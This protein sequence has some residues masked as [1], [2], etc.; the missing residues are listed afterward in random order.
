M[1]PQVLLILAAALALALPVFASGQDRPASDAA[2]TA[3]LADTKAALRDLWVGHI[4]WVRNVVDARFEDN[5]QAA[6]AAEQQVVANA[7]AIAGSIEPF[8]GAA[9]SEKLFGQLAG[10]WG[11]ISEYLDATRADSK[12]DQDAAFQQLVDNANEIAQFLGGANPHLPVD[13]LRSLLT[14]HG[15]PSRA[16]DPAVRHRPVRAGGGDLGD[17]EGSHVR[18][19][20]CA[21][22]RHRQAVPRQV[23]LIEPG[24]SCACL[25]LFSV[26][27]H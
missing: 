10:H 3:T 18:D 6:K 23:P 17:D 21:C 2:T 13:T 22:R 25:N 16:A 15:V 1:K 12:S 19:C 24:S 4:F 5:E 14:A 26:M 7:K 9:A 27:R 8:Y 20:R 11:A